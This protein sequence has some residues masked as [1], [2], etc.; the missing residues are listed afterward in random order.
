MGSTLQKAFGSDRMVIVA[1]CKSV[2]F[3]LEV[4]F[5]LPH[6][7]VAQLVEQSFDKR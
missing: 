2:G 7:P 1:D 4:R 5:S 6:L 3:S